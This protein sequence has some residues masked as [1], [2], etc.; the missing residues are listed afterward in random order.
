V[1]D[2]LKDLFDEGSRERGCSRF[3]EYADGLEK[4]NQKDKYHG[5]GEG[6]RGLQD[7]PG[8]GLSDMLDRYE[9]LSL[10]K[11]DVLVERYRPVG[12]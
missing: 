2:E 8:F 12:C 6:D 4:L 7:Y 10:G 9:S 3:D 5:I 1:P 11:D